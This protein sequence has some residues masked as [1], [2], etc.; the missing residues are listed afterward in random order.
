VTTPERAVGAAGEV[1]PTA[2]RRPTLAVVIVTYNST[3]YIGP[4]LASVIPQLPADGSRVVVVD[5]DSV[6]GTAEMVERDWL[7]AIVVRSGANLGFA[8]GCNLGASVLDADNVLF[9]NPDTRMAPGCIAALLDLAERR[10][11]AGLYG[12]RAV[13]PDGTFDPRSCF[14]RPTIWSLVCFATGLS[15]MFPSSTALNPEGIGGWPRDRERAVDVVSGCLLL[16]PRGVWEQL[17]GFDETFFMY[18]EDAD[19]CIRSAALGYRPMIT[20]A[21]GIVHVAGASS[22]AVSKEMLLFRGKAG[23]VRKIWSGPMQAVAVGLLVG[24]VGVRARL[25]A[26]AARVLPRAS[27]PERRAEPTTWSELWRR[28]GEWSQGW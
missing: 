5:N 23:L 3:G 18:G 10:P 17:E 1:T 8:R 19:L 6:D 7:D 15:S 24:G 20:P 22:P 16:A 26:L 13:G 21:A 11:D 4:C 14:G 25:A 12:G 28:R 2:A 27:R 9:L